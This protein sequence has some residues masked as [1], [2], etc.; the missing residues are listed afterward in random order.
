MR[1]EDILAEIDDLRDGMDTASRRIYELSRVLHHRMR[2]A[3]SANENASVYITYS[4]ALSRFAGIVQQGLNRTRQADRLLGLLSKTKE[5]VEVPPVEVPKEREEARPMPGTSALE[6][7][8]SVYGE[9][10]VRDADR[11]SKR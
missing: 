5:K 3:G 7:F 10:S 2:L 6:D 9:E 4:N 11:Q 8:I 1:P